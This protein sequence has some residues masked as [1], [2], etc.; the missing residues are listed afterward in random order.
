MLRNFNFERIDM[1]KCGMKKL[2]LR[3]LSYKEVIDTIDNFTFKIAILCFN[4][5]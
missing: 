3:T 5:D 4:S 1:I 2:L